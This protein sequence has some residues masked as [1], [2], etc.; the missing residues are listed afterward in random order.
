MEYN[1]YHKA[2]KLGLTSKDRWGEGIDHHPMSVRLM[3]FLEK[4]DLKDYNDYFGWQCGGDGDNGET[5]MYQMDA[6]FEL[7]EKTEKES[8]TNKKLR[9]ALKTTL[10]IL[11]DVN[12]INPSNYDHDEVCA[13]NASTVEAVLFLRKTL[14]GIE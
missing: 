2:K 6:F 10:E 4:H 14:E 5:L 3:E 11:E 13:M 9:E 8:K 1:D 12:E 7:M